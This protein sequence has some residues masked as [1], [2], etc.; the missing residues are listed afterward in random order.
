MT[1]ND[2][3]LAMLRRPYPLLIW[4]LIC[5]LAYLALAARFILDWTTRGGG[6][7]VWFFFPAIICGAAL[8]IITGIKKA[9]E[10]GN[11]RAML[12]VFWV[13]LFVIL[14]GLVFFLSMLI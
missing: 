9:D 1:M 2:K 7:I 14:M 4:A 13:H 6:I 12:A 8:I 10:N 3:I 5:G 11:T